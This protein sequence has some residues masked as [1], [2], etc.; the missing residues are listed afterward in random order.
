MGYWNPLC[1]SRIRS[2]IVYYTGGVDMFKIP[3]RS[4][5]EYEKAYCRMENP[6]NPDDPTEEEE[7]N[8][9]QE[10]INR[11]RFP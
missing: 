6:W 10:R 3:D 8:E 2:M 5:E 7:W 4:P 11:L 9:L 1:L